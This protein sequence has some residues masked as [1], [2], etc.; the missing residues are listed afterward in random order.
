MKYPLRSVCL[1]F[2]QKISL[3]KNGWIIEDLTVDSASCNCHVMSSL[4]KS[5]CNFKRI[6]YGLTSKR[7]LVIEGLG[8][9]IGIASWKI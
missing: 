5:T 1:E 8:P 7:V 3:L 4:L 9:Q 2:N 6:K